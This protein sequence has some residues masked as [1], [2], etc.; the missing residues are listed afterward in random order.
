MSLLTNFLS[1]KY[2]FEADQFAVESYRNSQVLIDALKKLSVDNLSNLH[3]HKL[4]VW[5]D[6]THPPVTERISAIRRRA[7]AIGV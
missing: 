6:Y 1:R 7:K 2:E 3:P 5:F 4:K